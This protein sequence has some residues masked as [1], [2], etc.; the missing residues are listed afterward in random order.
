[1]NVGDQIW[2]VQTE[3]SRREGLFTPIQWESCD[4]PARIAK[5]QEHIAARSYGN[6]PWRYI[7]FDGRT[8]R[9]CSVND[10]MKQ[11]TSEQGDV[12]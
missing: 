12:L 3:E 7:F 10:L 6:A 8:Y 1:M 5:R 4:R 9:F 2:E 11:M